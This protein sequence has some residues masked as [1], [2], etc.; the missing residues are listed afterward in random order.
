LI[1]IANISYTFDGG[2][3]GADWL[4]DVEDV[5]LFVPAKVVGFCG[6]VVL[7]LDWAVLRGGDEL[8]RKRKAWKDELR[9]VSR[10]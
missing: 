6:V 4:I 5:R 8:V 2:K 1:F 9:R 7:D 10:A 3:S